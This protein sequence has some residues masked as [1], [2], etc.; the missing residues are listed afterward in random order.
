MRVPDTPRER[1]D[2][3]VKPPAKKLHLPTYDSRWASIVQKPALRYLCLMIHQGAALISNFASNEITFI[4]VLT[5][6]LG[7]RLLLH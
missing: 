4:L 5:S 3:W 6:P 7:M 2:L 1:G